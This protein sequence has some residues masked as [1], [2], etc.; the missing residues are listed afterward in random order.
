MAPPPPPPTYS[1]NEKH[2]VQ[3]FTAGGGGGAVRL[4]RGRGGG[5]CS[6]FT[7][8]G[9]GGGAVRFRSDTFVWHTLLLIMNDY[10]FIL[11]EGGAQAPGA[12]PPM[13]TPLL[14]YP[15]QLSACI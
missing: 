13:D 10:N 9:G 1:G 4:R 15:H 11:T 12:P 8:G 7:A 2:A 6:P 5:G 14:S 3:T